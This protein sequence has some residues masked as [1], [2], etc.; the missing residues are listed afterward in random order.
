M[1][2]PKILQSAKWMNAQERAMAAVEKDISAIL[3]HINTLEVDRDDLWERM[4]RQQAKAAA[5][6]RREVGKVDKP[7]DEAQS[8]EELDLAIKEGRYH[9]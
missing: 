4:H 5:R 8:V 6:A 3:E 1:W 2:L 9:D 7:D